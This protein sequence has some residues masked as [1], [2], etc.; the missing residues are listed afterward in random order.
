MTSIVP[1]SLRRH[2]CSLA[3]SMLLVLLSGASLA[4]TASAPATPRGSAA[5]ASRVLELIDAEEIPLH[6]LQVIVGDAMQRARAGLDTRVTTDKRDAAMKDIGEIGRKT[7]EESTPIVR[8]AAKKLAPA[9]AGAFL[10]EHFTDEELR[11][12]IAMLESPVR[13]KFEKLLPQMQRSVGEAVAA[14]TRPQVDPKLK[15]MGK[16]ITDKMQKTVDAR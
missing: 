7:L 9:T 8:A 14:E 16:A 10:Q 5:L 2:T 11:Q 12:V 3:A 6:R 4:Q 1:A 15:E 13:K